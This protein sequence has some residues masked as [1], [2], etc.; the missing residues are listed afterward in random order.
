MDKYAD[1]FAKNDMDLGNF[2]AIQHHINTGKADSQVTKMGR[3]PLHF[4]DEEEKHLQQMLNANVIQPSISAW[5]SASVFI[6]KKDGSL[7]WCIDYRQVNAVI[8]K[9]TYPLPF[10]SECLDSLDGNSW[11]SKLDANSAYCQVPVAKDSQAKTVFRTKF[12]L[13]E[14]K[15]LPFG[16]TNSPATFGRVMALVLHG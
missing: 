14:S 6:R 8:V 15:K 10:L 3:V 9:D 16:L 4:A 11:Y 13:Y 2:T 5:A 1:V 12:G 7:R